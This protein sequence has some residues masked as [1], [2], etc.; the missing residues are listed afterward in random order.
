MV[1]STC[2]LCGKQT[3]GERSWTKMELYQNQL[4]DLPNTS[5]DVRLL[6]NYKGHPTGY[7]GSPELCIDCMIKTSNLVLEH[8]LHKKELDLG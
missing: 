3:L 8:L 4:V 7:A 1:D 5:L 6:M 2:E